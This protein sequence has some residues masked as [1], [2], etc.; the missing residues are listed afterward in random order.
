VNL[1]FLVEGT[2]E[3]KIYPK[4]L[5]TLL[6]NFTRVSSPD[7]ATDFNYFLISGG[8]FPHL[9]DKGLPNSAADIIETGNYNYF[10]V[11]LD[12]DEATVNERSHEVQNKFDA[13]N[14]QLGRCQTKIIVQNRCIETWLLGNRRIFQ[15]NPQDIELR[16]YIN[17]FNVHWNDPE[18]MYKPN[19]FDESVG[20]YHKKYLK[21][22][23]AERNISYS[24]KYPRETAEPYYLQAL[25]DRTQQTP[26]HLQSLQYFFQLCRTIQNQSSNP[27]V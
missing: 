27:V 8:G 15:R 5:E 10:I 9:L 20:W 6:P 24:E 17:F 16:S 23:L 14:I 4:W 26:T 3:R 18:L 12:A 25:Q 22:M 11:V 19:N 7:S 2:T 13:F 21:L 1:Y